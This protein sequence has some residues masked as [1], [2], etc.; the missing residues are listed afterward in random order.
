M[1][2]TSRLAMLHEIRKSEEKVV[3]DSLPKDADYAAYGIRKFARIEISLRDPLKLREFAVELRELAH[4][5]DQLSRDT[6]ENPVFTM[7][8]VEAEVNRTNQVVRGT[9]KSGR[10]VRAS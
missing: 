10:P 9:T 7:M 1:V 8:K 6:V 3:G 5:L 4:R 2:Q